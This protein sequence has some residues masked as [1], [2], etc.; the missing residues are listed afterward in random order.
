MNYIS[1]NNCLDSTCSVFTRRVLPKCIPSSFTSTTLMDYLIVRQW[2]YITYIS[3]VLT[4]NAVSET[5][6]VFFHLF[7][8]LVCSAI[9]YWFYIFTARASSPEVAAKMGGTGIIETIVMSILIGIPFSAVSLGGAVGVLALMYHLC[10]RYRASSLGRFI[11]RLPGIRCIPYVH[12]KYWLPSG[13]S[14]RPRPRFFYL[15]RFIVRQ[16][17]FL[18]HFP[19]SYLLN[20]VSCRC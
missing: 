15:K 17:E 3:F 4:L 12:R 11:A 6:I 16:S 1:V 13:Q 18:C 2:I 9:S 20:H 14:L 8:L 7:A 19:Y 5:A 10:W